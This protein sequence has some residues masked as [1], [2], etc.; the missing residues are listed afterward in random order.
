MKIL[1][2]GPLPKEAGGSYTSGICKVV[3]ELSKQ[4]TDGVNYH[5]IAL[6]L[7]Q[8]VAERNNKY[9]FQFNGYKWMI[10]DVLSDFLFHSVK[11]YR[12]MRYY[13]RELHDNPFKWE[14]YKVNIKRVIKTIRPDIIH[15]HQYI[16]ATYFAN[17]YSV[18]IIVTMHGVFYR[19]LKEQ[20]NLK[21]LAYSLVNQAD[22]YTGLTLECEKY[23]TGLFKIPSNKMEIIP[24]GTNTSIYYFSLDER[25]KMRDDFK[26][27]NDTIVFVTVASIQERKGQLRFIKVLE[28]LNV[29]FLYWIIGEG[30][31][32][33]KVRNYII[34]NR[35]EE[36]VKLLGSI[37]SNELY[38]YYS[39]ADIYAHPS[40]MEG[41]SLSEMEAYATGLRIVVNE[42]IKD[43]IA[44][45]GDKDCYY[46]LNMDRVEK[47]DFCNWIEKRDN[48]RS[49]K[50]DL[51]W[52]VIS[53]KYA[54]FYNKILEGEI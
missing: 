37:N 12:E 23:M 36:S 32:K 16:S 52:N 24:N 4:Y 18:P 50:K 33:S 26:I 17:I 19:G 1:L 28:K 51:D 46:I 47:K 21:G 27:N 34:D 6:N 40:T 42:D 11:T 8:K 43:T 45:I 53:N 5:V 49:S 30:P 20:E 31:D 2:V 15:V 44:T 48:M 41:Q 25:K 38:K 13:K 35:L 7:P 9:P 54:D 22:Y 39:A 10:K 29:K 14:F 3:Y